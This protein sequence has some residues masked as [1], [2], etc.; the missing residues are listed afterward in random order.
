MK[1]VVPTPL[2]GIRV[3]RRYLPLRVAEASQISLLDAYILLKQLSYE[4]YCR[5]YKWYAYRRL[6]AV[7]RRCQC[8]SFSR[9]LPAFLEEREVVL[10]P[11]PNTTRFN[12]SYNILD[13]ISS[14]DVLVQNGFLLFFYYH[15]CLLIVSWL[16][17]TEITEITSKFA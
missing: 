2:S 7:Y 15:I 1:N 17:V 16:N 3:K 11:F 13:T 6:I 8:Y 4:E 12:I 14:I 10:S 9:L 5:C